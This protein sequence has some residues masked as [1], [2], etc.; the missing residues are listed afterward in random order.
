VILVRQGLLEGASFVCVLVQMDPDRHFEV[1]D[2]RPYQALLQMA[3]LVVHHRGLPEL[4][5]EKLVQ[6]AFRIREDGA[7]SRADH[8]LLMTYGT[9]ASRAPSKLDRLDGFFFQP[10]WA[11][12]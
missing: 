7:S 5:P 1:E 6:P 4:L 3:D 2:V 12:D 10:I 8:Y 11:A 9:A